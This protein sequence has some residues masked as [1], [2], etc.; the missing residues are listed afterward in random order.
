[1]LLLGVDG[2]NC[3][4]GSLRGEEMVFNWTLGFISDNAT[5]TLRNKEAEM[6]ANLARNIYYYY[7]QEVI[8]S[9]SS[10]TFPRNV[11]FSCSILL[12][13]DSRERTLT[14]LEWCGWGVLHGMSSQAKRWTVPSW[15]SVDLLKSCRAA[16]ETWIV[17]SILSSLLRLVSVSHAERFVPCFFFWYFLMQN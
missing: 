11:E 9:K 12:E 14:R 4:Q 15:K 3:W 16:N 10:K 6:S 2:W 13:T 7:L 17:L 5:E 8:F 1:M